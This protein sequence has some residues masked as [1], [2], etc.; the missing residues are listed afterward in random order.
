MIEYKL[1][2]CVLRR[3]KDAGQH[4]C[5]AAWLQQELRRLPAEGEHRRR[6]E[7]DDPPGAPAPGGGREKPRGVFQT[8]GGTR[9]HRWW[10]MGWWRCPRWS[11]Q[12]PAKD[13]SPSRAATASAPSPVPTCATGWPQTP[14]QRTALCRRRAL[15]HGSSWWVSWKG[16]V[17]TRRRVRCGPRRPRAARRI[18]PPLRPAA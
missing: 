13:A 3:S 6:V 9:P 18:A 15:R 12:C 14:A 7:G 16:P 17:P 8:P 5:A 10:R 2:A 11:R 4:G 1:L